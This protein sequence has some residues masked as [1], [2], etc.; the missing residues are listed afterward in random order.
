MGREPGSFRPE[1]RPRWPARSRPP[2][3]T[4]R[5]AKQ[6]A[7]GIARWWKPARTGRATWERSR[8]SL[9]GSRTRGACERR[10]AAAA[11]P[12]LLLSAARW[13]RS[14]SRA[15]MDPPS[16]RRG[17]ALH[18][19]VRGRGR[20]LGAGRFGGDPGRHRG[21]S[22]ARRERA[23][24]LAASANERQRGAALGRHLRYPAAPQRL[25]AAARFLRGMGA[26]GAGGGRPA[27]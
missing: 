16:P 4:R 23:V 22:R 9:A 13:W 10:R 6:R 14:A 15:G 21:D 1:T 18:G 8:L 7:L 3:R 2:W 5:G 20:L 25:V 27:A 11:D 17:L 12:Q 24:L 26:T 19:G